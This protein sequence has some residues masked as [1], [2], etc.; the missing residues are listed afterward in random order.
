M[1]KA[2]E[3]ALLMCDALSYLLISTYPACACRADDSNGHISSRY[4]LA[5]GST[6]SP[7]T[8][9]SPEPK[10]FRR[11]WSSWSIIAGLVQT[12]LFD[13]QQPAFLVAI[14]YLRPQT[15]A[16]GYEPLSR[17]GS[18]RREQMSYSMS[19]KQCRTRPTAAACR[20]FAY[21]S[22]PICSQ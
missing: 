21:K 12:S 6:G 16:R 14:V 18:Q 10:A 15:S 5:Q 9:F 2:A 4:G 7:R 8:R 3:A 19:Q 17:Y 22:S 11:H 13:Q 20:P 1:K